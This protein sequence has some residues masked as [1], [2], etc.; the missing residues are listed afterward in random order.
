[1]KTKL[2]FKGNIEGDYAVCNITE[3]SKHSNKPNVMFLPSAHCVE[4]M[5]DCE[6][7]ISLSDFNKLEKKGVII[8]KY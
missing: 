2:Y 4:Y 3:L 5:E 7:E 8:Y 6:I 1:M